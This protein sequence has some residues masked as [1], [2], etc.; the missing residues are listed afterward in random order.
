AD[1]IICDGASVT[2]TATPAGATNYEFFINGASV[3]NSGSRTF[4]TSTLDDG[5]VVNVIVTT[6]AGCSATSAG[7]ATTVNPLPSPVLSSSDADNTICAD[8]SVTF[9]ATPI[10]AANYTFSITGGGVVSSASNSFTP[11]TLN[12]GDVVDVIVE[13]AAGCTATSAGIATT[14]NALP[15][16][17]LVSSDADDIICDGASVT[18]TATPSGAANYDFLVNGASAQSSGSNT[19]T[20]NALNN[21]DVVSVVVTSA[22]G[23]TATSGTIT[24]TVNPLP[25]PVLSSSDADNTI[26]ADES[27]T[28]TAT[29]IGAANYTFRINGGV[30]VTSASNSFTP[31]TLNNGDVV[32][33][34]VETA[35]GCT[36]TSA[37]IATTVNALPSANLVSSDADDIICDGATV[38]FTATPSGAAN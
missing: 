38:T 36:A 23:C 14:V 25:S 3:Q 18:F 30:V 34:I 2:F 7:I 33:V 28:F 32:D 11:A 4:T 19:F 15:S 17:N 21:G 6:A 31:A 37:G 12:N 16:A 8:E 9:T 5:D 35:A 1:D 10:G 22:A 24:T 26:C 20:T 29:P 13:T 27:V